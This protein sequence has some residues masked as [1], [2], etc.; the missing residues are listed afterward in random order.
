MVDPTR[1]DGSRCRIG[2]IQPE[3]PEVEMP[4]FRGERYE[5][6]VPDTLD[7]AERA[8]LAI[9]AMTENPDPDADYEPLWQVELL[10]VPRMLADYG[11]SASA[12]KMR[13]A[14][15]LARIMSGSDLN[16]Q[17]D[18]RWMETALK[19]QGP[20]GLI[21]IPSR[22]RPWAYALNPS[23]YG[24]SADATADQTIS[25][26]VNGLM[27]RAMSLYAARDPRSVW[28]ER[29][30]KVVDG[31]TDLAVDA[32]DFAYF[33]P[34]QQYAVKNPPAD[35]KP[36]FHYV[37]ME[38][39]AI[40]FGL[41]CAY[42]QTGYEPALKLTRKLIAFQK[43]FFT[44]EGAFLTAQKG[45]IKA[46]VHGHARGLLAMA[47]YAMLADDR[48]LLEF[49]RKSYEWTKARCDP[50]TGFTP[51]LVPCPE[52]RDPG[53]DAILSDK[54]DPLHTEAS[55]NPCEIAGLTD[56][57]GIALWLTEAGVGDY[58]DDVDRWV[59][60]ML[61]E[62][63]MLH[64]DWIRN[65][66]IVEKATL[67]PRPGQSSERVIERC[68]GAW[69]TAALPNDF[70]A[71]KPHHFAGFLMPDTTT[72]VRALYWTWHRMLGHRDGKLQV[73]LFLNRASKWADVDSHI[74]YTGRVDVRIKQAVE[75]SVRIPEWVAPDQVRVKVDGVDPDPG[76]RGRYAEV[77]RVEPGQTAT[78]TFPIGDHTEKVWIEKEHY[79]LSRR[80]NNVL[81]ISPR[82][83]WY[84]FYQGE[85][86]RSG[87]TRWRE[88][89][90]F[91]PEHEV[92]W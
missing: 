56:L 76:W 88:Q 58:W 12:A 28:K 89:A 60:N 25:P 51:N 3:V 69:P 5:S 32:G 19:C 2:Y 41:T 70:L 10:P 44:P 35:V 85:H 13:E 49:V 77:G 74:P 17:V 14:V 68:L 46:H 4:P 26:Y 45:A 52:W 57:V 31:L 90:R 23:H 24:I 78:L 73:N 84:P 15:T 47:D 29:I 27:L 79:T 80:G 86:Y 66:P 83:Q 59:R 87:Q 67:D 9:H 20:D 18:R 50:L 48:D 64:T 63:Q 53:I 16:P 6:M 22:G 33:W 65:L 75:L 71:V 30:C 72:S 8:R 82:G 91:I 34:D 38:I 39:N 7:L 42:K 21:Y 62:A 40:F 11:S 37:G 55:Y 36:I 81:S 54:E 61:S 1:G 43:F 92:D